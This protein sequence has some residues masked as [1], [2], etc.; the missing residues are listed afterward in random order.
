MAEKVLMIA[1]SPTMESGTI[2][3]W[4]KQEGDFVESGDVL[5]EVETDKATMEYESTADG[6][7]LKILRKQG[8]EARIEEPIAVLGEK[9]EDITA[10]LRDIAES[11][12]EK[13]KRS[14]QVESRQKE[15]VSTQKGKS[16]REAVS[17]PERTSSPVAS[18]LTENTQAVV[19]EAL[20]SEHRKASPLAR[21]LAQQHG[22]NLA[23]IR[24]SGPEGRIIKRDIEQALE[25]SAGEP[26]RQLRILA[27]IETEEV[28]L[29]A[30]RKV[31]AQRISESKFSAPHYYLRTVVAMDI[32]M[33][34]RSQ[35][36][37]GREEKVSLNAFI[38]KF[39]AEALKRHRNVNSGWGGDKIILFGRADIGLAVAQQ[40]G[41]ITPIVRDCWNK[42]IIQIDRELRPLVE[43]A[44]NNRLKPEEYTGATF[45]I[46]NLGS[47]GIL[48]F[49]AIINPPGSAI[50]AVGQ[51]RKEPAVEEDGQIRVHSNMTLTLSCDHRV[52]DGAEGAL[53]LKDLKD[54]MENPVQS[55]Y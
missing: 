10:L 17:A 12:P 5:C 46:S 43:K 49:T 11:E 51:I 3:K 28:A 19:Q 8:E 31:I 4:R 9:G 30:K 13:S 53:F 37:R 45:T 27:P 47:F 15:D 6:T 24:G 42:G 16:T 22:F 41:L 35:L 7:L 38:I 23:Q 48:E 25:H 1:L 40:D 32:L 34:A 20:P 18:R 52:F 50:L 33:A 26:E 36:N 54:L 21:Q 29:S 44:L 39:V 55:L 2:L 14:E